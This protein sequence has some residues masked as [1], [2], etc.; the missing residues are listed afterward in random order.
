MDLGHKFLEVTMLSYMR[1]DSGQVLMNADNK[2]FVYDNGNVKDLGF[3]VGM[4]AESI[5]NKGHITGTITPPHNA[6]I[7]KDGQMILLGTLPGYSSSSGAFAINNADWVVGIST[8]AS[9]VTRAFLYNGSQM[10]DMGCLDQCVSSIARDVS[11]NG[12]A[13]GMC[14]PR[15]L[16]LTKAFVYN[17]NGIRELGTLGGGGW[18]KQRPSIIIWKLWVSQMVN[19][20]FG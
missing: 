13:C 16:V 10:L 9:G 3:E 6:Y 20:S 18:R 1:N 14:T 19:L 2:S 5:N 15:D 7:F 17:A 4:A 8:D 11:D 12:I